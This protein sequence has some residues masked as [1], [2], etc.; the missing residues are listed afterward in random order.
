M[1]TNAL[2]LGVDVGGIDLTLHCGYPGTKNSL[3][4]Q[5]GR[6]GRGRGCSSC[7][8]VVCFNSPSEQYLWKAPQTIL[9]KAVGASSALPISGSVLQGHLLCAGEEFP[10]T[11]SESVSCLLNEI[12]AIRSTC[13]SDE[14]LFG[15]GSA[16]YESVDHLV[17]KSVL[18][19]KVV[20]AVRSNQQVSRF[21]CHETHPVSKNSQTNKQTHQHLSSDL[22]LC[23]F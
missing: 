19:S 9:S 8:I 17:D 14:E 16:Y 23:H 20:R 13:P 22:C 4:Q 7:A 6:A 21:V 3:L 10:L 1:G 5:S 18:R 11:G 2:E 12:R 15:S